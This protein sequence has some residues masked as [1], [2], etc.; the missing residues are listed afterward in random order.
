MIAEPLVC[1]APHRPRR[2]VLLVDDEPWVV[3]GLRKAL[4]PY[5]AR[6]E[7]DTATSGEEAI[8]KLQGPEFDAVV[9]DARM[10]GADGVK[11]LEAVQARSPCTLRVVLSGQVAQV[12]L[13]K[14]ERLAHHFIPKPVGAGVL[15]ARLE[16]SL[17]ARDRLANPELKALII[18]LGNLPAFPE[19]FVELNRMQRE[20]DGDLD[21][22]VRVVEQD[23]AATTNLL[24]VVNSAW[25]GLPG[26]V[27]SI[28]EAVRLMGI[29]PLTHAVL[30]TSMFRGPEA[31]A[32]RLEHESVK[33]LA[34]LHTLLPL[35]G[36]EEFVEEASTALVLLDV[37]QLVLQ[38]GL[39]QQ[40]ARV[41][42]QVRVGGDRLAAEQRLVGIDHA[43]LGGSLL[44]V[45]NLPQALVEAVTLHHLSRLETKPARSLATLVALVSA[46][47]QLVQ[48]QPFDA[49]ALAAEAQVLAAA[50]GN[51]DLAELTAAFGTPPPAAT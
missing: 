7:V 36:A 48:P 40:A 5:R 12:D 44:S 8:E 38:L 50:F 15:F 45:W 20:D 24:R 32:R 16:E 13:K 31:L 30:A 2:R 27:A 25:F 23:P 22:Y 28:R 3:Q 29:R 34:A 42:Q 21:D 26:R 35:L 9:T 10:P 18:R 11:V 33:R 17:D 1:N 49:E 47:Q 4:Y 19:T 39:P 41:E 14:V 37:G 43:H 6:W 51:E 46:L